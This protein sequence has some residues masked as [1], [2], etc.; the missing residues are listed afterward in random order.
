MKIKQFEK[1]SKKLIDKLEYSKVIA[2]F[3]IENEVIKLDKFDV[4]QTLK[5]SNLNLDNIK[6]V[7]KNF[8]KETKKVLKTYEKLSNKLTDF[9]QEIKVVGEYEVEVKICQCGLYVNIKDEHL[10]DEKTLNKIRK[11]FINEL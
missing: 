10:I 3:K 4:V 7:S 11:V 9:S 6:E 2:K 1:Q 5:A 8:K